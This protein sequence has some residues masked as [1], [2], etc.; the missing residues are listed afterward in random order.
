MIQQNNQCRPEKYKITTFLATTSIIG[1]LLMFV[2]VYNASRELE[3]MHEVDSLHHFAQ[4]YLA[5]LSAN[6]TS[7]L[8]LPSLNANNYRLLVLENS[9]INS[10]P[11]SEPINGFPVDVAELE[12]SRVNERGGSIEIGDTHYSWSMLTANGSNRTPVFVHPYTRHT[13]GTLLKVYSKRL[14][15][16]AIFYVWLMVWGAF[17][18]R[19]LTKKLKAQNDELEHLALHDGLTGLPNRMLLED[20]LQKLIHDS[21]RGKR[22]FALAVIDLNGFKAIN[23]TYG[24]DQGD[25]LLRQFSERVSDALRASDTCAR[26]GGDEFVL[27]LSDVDEQTCTTMCNRIKNSVLQPY[28]LRDAG[29]TI[30]LSIGVSIFPDHGETPTRL[31]RNADKAMYS[32]KSKGG[33]I[34][35]YAGE[36]NKIKTILPGS[37]TKS[38]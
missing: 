13:P 9:K 6:N 25:E 21:Q 15:I 18:I 17:I 23:D 34:C 16:P 27:L 32:I 2:A 5:R 12:K 7:I 8:E 38:A 37:A 26:M 4:S 36:E 14:L 35:I 19:F 29:I 20:R 24:H 11:G 22:K 3:S 10:L 1:I 28:H 33:G 31:M 30:G